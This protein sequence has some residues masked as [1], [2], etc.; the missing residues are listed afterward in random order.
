VV[1]RSI[2]RDGKARIRAAIPRSDVAAGG[3]SEAGLMAWNAKD[4]LAEDADRYVRGKWFPR[5]ANGRKN[6]RRGGR[7]P[8]DAGAKNNTGYSSW[9]ARRG[10]GRRA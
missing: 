5:A 8:F 4:S 6:E 1:E 7:D 3:I 9:I 2:R 10:K